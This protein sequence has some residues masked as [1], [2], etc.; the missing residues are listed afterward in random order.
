MVVSSILRRQLSRPVPL[1]LLSNTFSSLS[2]RRRRK[3]EGLQFEND[4]PKS[5]KNDGPIMLEGFRPSE[6]NFDD[7]LKKA[8]LSPWV[9]V[10]DA[11]ARK[12]LELAQAGPNDIHVELGSG[13]GRMNFHALDPPFSVQKSLG[14]DIDEKLINLANERK[15]KRHPQPTNLEFHIQDLLGANAT[16][17][18]TIAEENVTVIT[19]FFV[20]DALRL[21]RPKLEES[22]KDRKCRIVCCGYPVPEWNEHWAETMLDLKIFVYNYG[23]PISDELPKLSEEDMALMAKL[24]NDNKVVASDQNSK[25]PTHYDPYDD[26]EEIK[27]PLFDPNEKIDY[28]WDDFDNEEAEAE[29]LDGNPAISKWRQPE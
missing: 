5:L 9:P 29:D 21:L 19:M 25:S 15:A 6:D 28:H 13:D 27:I 17:W 24:E 2:H 16:I 11:V 7:Y 14:V 20:E 10:P 23:S 22:L 1:L 8:S 12:M 4:S 26:A 18:K 3:K